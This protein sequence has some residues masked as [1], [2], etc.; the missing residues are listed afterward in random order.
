MS[1]DLFFLPDITEILY[2]PSS[3]EFRGSWETSLA[4]TPLLTQRFALSGKLVLMLG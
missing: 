4:P 2:F 1:T 3:K